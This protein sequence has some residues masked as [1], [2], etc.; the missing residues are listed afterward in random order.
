MPR[1]AKGRS[2]EDR[3]RYTRRV[4]RTQRALRESL[5][6]LV[7]ERGW[8]AVSVQE[9]CERAN[10]GRSTFYIHFA[11]KDE[12]LLSG[13][14]DLADTLRA[15]A[16]SEPLGFLRPLI[17]HVRDH[18]AILRKLL[19]NRSAQAVEQRLLEVVNE[20]VAAELART[21]PPGP[22]RDAAAHYAAGGLVELLVFWLKSRSRM[23]I[24]D[25]ERTARELTLPVLT[26]ARKRDASA[27]GTARS[28]PGRT[29]DLHS[30]G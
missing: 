16:S 18:Y 8:N 20:R 2:A 14:R 21:A 17:E 29:M 23:P 1:K 15:A 4:A 22:R 10:V 12:L 6:S 19:S 11:D 30:P 7:M 25:V 13:F 24:Q 5:L 9:L 27:S 26:A 3:Q 28:R